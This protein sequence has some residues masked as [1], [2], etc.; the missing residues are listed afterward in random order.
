MVVKHSRA[1]R[2]HDNARMYKRAERMVSV[3]ESDPEHLEWR[4]RRIYNNMKNCSCWMCRNERNNG[5]NS[6]RLSLTRQEQKAEDSFNDQLK[7]I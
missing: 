6:G 5:W 7:E 3:W 2:R 4:V 1:Q